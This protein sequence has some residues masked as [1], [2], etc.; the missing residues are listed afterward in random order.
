MNPKRAAA[1]DIG[2]NSVRLLI[3]QVGLEAEKPEL[4]T[5]HRIM[6]ITRLGE[7]VDESDRLKPDAI[8]RTL[9]ILKSYSKLPC[10]A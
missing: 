7:G 3:A 5:L 4:E 9:R 2:T 1:I 8:E 6:N 10:R